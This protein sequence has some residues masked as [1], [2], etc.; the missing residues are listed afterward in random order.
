LNPWEPTFDCCWGG[1][2]I[3]RCIVAARPRQRVVLSGTVVDSEPC[4]W[5]GMAAQAITLDDGTGQLTLMFGGI[6]SIP[7]MIAG[8]RCTV[9]GTALPDERGLALWNPL[10][11]FEP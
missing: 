3:A 1:R 2:P 8:V 6:R 10:Y 4:I 9:E 11:R 5:R 7:G